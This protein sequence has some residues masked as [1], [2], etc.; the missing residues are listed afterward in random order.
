LTVPGPRVALAPNPGYAFGAE[1]GN[2]CPPIGYF[3]S[4]PYAAHCRST[5]VDAR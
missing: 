2:L 4:A 3:E 1:S 5:E